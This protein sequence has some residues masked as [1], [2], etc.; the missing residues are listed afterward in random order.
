MCLRTDGNGGLAVFR[1]RM[2][3]SLMG[4]YIWSSD[5]VW[6]AED[7]IVSSLSKIDR[8]PGISEST[9]S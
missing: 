3:I 5:S 7:Q 6:F 4:R 2:S 8:A 9:G 1:G